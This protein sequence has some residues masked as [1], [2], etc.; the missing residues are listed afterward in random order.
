M[1]IEVWECSHRRAT[2]LPELLAAT[3]LGMLLAFPL[4]VWCSYKLS[5]IVSRHPQNWNSSN[6]TR[7]LRVP[8]NLS[9][10]G[11]RAHAHP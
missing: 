5:L 3:A 2:K 8:Q 11:A 10:N 6:C 1:S 9:T 4:G 7:V